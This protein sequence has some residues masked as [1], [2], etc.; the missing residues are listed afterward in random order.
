MFCE[1]HPSLTANEEYKECNAYY[2]GCPP[3][4]M[5]HCPEADSSLPVYAERYE[6]PVG[7]ERPVHPAEAECET[8]KYPGYESE[9]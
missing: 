7:D 5:E 6:Y 2:N 9:C 8:D 1:L 4:W 3:Q